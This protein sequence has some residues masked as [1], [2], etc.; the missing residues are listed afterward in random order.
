MTLKLLLY[1]QS[2]VILHGLK[3]G[4]AKSEE[5]APKDQWP[6]A[7]KVRFLVREHT[8]PVRPLKPKLNFYS[9]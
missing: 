8:G 6:V 4:I 5:I 1:V 3:N 9:S 7:G 2:G